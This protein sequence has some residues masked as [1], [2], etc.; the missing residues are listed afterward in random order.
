MFW[1]VHLPTLWRRTTQLLPA[2]FA[3]NRW[4]TTNV[5]YENDDARPWTL[6]Q[7]NTSISVSIHSIPA[8][9]DPIPNHHG[10]VGFTL[11]QIVS[12]SYV[13]E[14]G[15][16]V[17]DYSAPGQRE[18]VMTCFTFFGQSECL[19]WTVRGELSDVEKEVG[20]VGC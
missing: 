6:T 14:N 17:T 8:D 12:E 13:L 7:P 10:H 5:T 19:F 4:V 16:K 11:E 20:E 1:S 18:V 15:A 3:V 2:D 9:D